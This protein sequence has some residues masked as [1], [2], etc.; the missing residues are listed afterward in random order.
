MFLA[1]KFGTG[2][3]R[4]TQ[5]SAFNIDDTVES[6]WHK[7]I[8][9]KVMNVS[10]KSVILCSILMRESFPGSWLIPWQ[11][12]FLQAQSSDFG[13]GVRHNPLRCAGFNNRQ[14]VVNDWMQCHWSDISV[15]L[16]FKTDE[17]SEK[18]FERQAA[19]YVC[20]ERVVSLLNG[21]INK[22]DFMVGWESR[23]GVLPACRSWLIVGELIFIRSKG[24]LWH[25][26]LT[27]WLQVSIVV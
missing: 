9:N 24:E 27:I 14:S 22:A 6:L 7:L 5:N 2:S 23:H 3:A 4:L 20:V 1:F 25:Q 12:D 21:H 19:F 11:S 18:S 13:N 16:C 15:G 26:T 17:L 10:F 8:T